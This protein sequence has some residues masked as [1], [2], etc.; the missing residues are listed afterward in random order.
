VQTAGYGAYQRVQAETSSPGEVIVL[1][2]DALLKNLR[3]GIAAIEAGEP[4]RVNEAL[5]R[6]QDIVLE[7]HTSLD[8]SAEI[9]EQL[10]PL[11]AYV[12]RNLVAANVNKDA[13]TVRELETMIAPM[14]DAWVVAVRGDASPV[15]AS[16]EATRA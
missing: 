5:T 12:F 7:L 1:L 6:A 3:R 2:Y 15:R 8:A 10:S 13:R 4:D 16:Q 14:R 11:Y 9:A